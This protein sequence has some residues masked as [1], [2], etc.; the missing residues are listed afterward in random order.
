VQKNGRFVVLFL[1]IFAVA[2]AFACT[3]ETPP[4]S[5]NDPPPPPRPGDVPPPPGDGAPRVMVGGAGSVPGEPPPGGGAFAPGIGSFLRPVPGSLFQLAPEEIAAKT[6]ET[7]T[8]VEKIKAKGEKLSDYFP[9]MLE[10]AKLAEFKLTDAV[11]DLGAGTGLFGIALLEHDVPFGKL[12]EV[13]ID[14]PSLKMGEQMREWLELPG[15]EKIVAVTSTE[16]D[17]KL[18]ANSIDVGVM[19]HSPFYRGKDDPSGKLV[20]DPVSLH[21]IKTFYDAIKPGG[22]VVI[23]ERAGGDDNVDIKPKAYTTPFEKAG[24]RVESKRHFMF[25]A[26]QNYHIVFVK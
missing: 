26:M 14:Q 17:V 4:P 7:K 8:A 11:A 9:K 23:I 24:F 5:P 15:R 18:A 6:A 25:F 19:I 13:D 1:L 10:L 2:L 12:Y 20:F 16:A 3:A 22:R 21:C